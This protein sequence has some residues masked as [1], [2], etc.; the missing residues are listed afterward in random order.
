MLRIFAVGHLCTAI[1]ITALQAVLVVAA[2][3]RFGHDTNVGWLYAAVGAGGVVGS[4]TQL[5]WTPRNVGRL[6]I[7][8]AVLGEL[9]PLGL[10]AIATSLAQAM[11]LLF[12]SSLFGALY[13]TRGAIA[14]QRRVP[15]ELLGR[16]NAVIRFSLYVGMLVGAVLAAV[17]IAWVRWDHL[18]LYATAAAALVLVA[19]LLTGPR[20]VPAEI[21]EVALAGR[22][23]HPRQPP[24]L[25]GIAG[26]DRL[27]QRR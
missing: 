5:R 3:E 10:F 21:P 22:S 4:I 2:S 15:R 23:L 17:A 12:V 20:D 8:S 7:A 24:G 6:G 13:Q 14:L 25:R 19:A 18:L 26:G 11:A 9:V 1:V 27:Q 16:V